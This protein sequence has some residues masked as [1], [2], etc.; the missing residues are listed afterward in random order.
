MK[1]LVWIILGAAACGGTGLPI[2]DAPLA[3][4]SLYLTVKDIG[5]HC[6]V[7]INGEEPFTSAEESLADFDPGQ[8]IPLT[9]SATNGFTLGLWHHTAHDT[10]SGDPG[11][12]SDPGQDAQSSTS[13]TLDDAPGC[14]WIC[15]SSG[16]DDCPTTDQCQL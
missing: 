12:I 7:T 2:V 3:K 15:C 11:A 4:D 13:V 16:S 14:V 1:H 8:T 5:G 6:S 9:A 10:G